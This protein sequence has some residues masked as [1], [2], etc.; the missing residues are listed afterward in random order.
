MSD[1]VRMRHSKNKKGHLD[2]EPQ[3]KAVA[4]S[5]KPSSEQIK[6][7]K[8]VSTKANFHPGTTLFQS[9]QNRGGLSIFENSQV[10]LGKSNTKES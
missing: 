4:K 10:K 6:Q 9:V 1:L 7:K 5:K 3:E 2:K 8:I